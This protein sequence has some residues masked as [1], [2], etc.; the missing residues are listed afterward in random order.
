MRRFLLF[1]M[2]ILSACQT[3]IKNAHESKA[4]DK[5]NPDYKSIIEGYWY[6]PAYIKDIDQ[7]KSPYKSRNVLKS[8]V[9]LRINTNEI[10]GDSL[11]IGAFNIHEGGGFFIFLKP[12]I[13]PD[14]FP[15]NMVD[16]NNTSNCYE[17]GYLMS[18]K[19]TTMVIYHYNKQKQL[20][21]KNEYKKAPTNPDGALPYMVNKTLFAG[22]YSTADT[23]GKPITIQL[24]SDGSVS[25][26]PGFN[27]YELSIDFLDPENT[28]DEI[29]FETH[30]GQ[31]KYY[32]YEIKGN[33]INLYE[34]IKDEDKISSKRGQ[35]SYKLVR[36]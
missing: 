23:T 26:W 31:R 34:S 10:K 22:K 3:N 32:A 11:E 1:A 6:D 9:E 29:G 18:G 19:D 36:L 2:A 24:G 20:I 14:S 13:G 17:L 30:T 25:G 35:L 8:I 33:A 16:Y 5:I 15:T 21:D 27:K 4:T 12:G 28:Q 7:T